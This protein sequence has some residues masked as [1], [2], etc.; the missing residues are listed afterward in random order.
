M[1]KSGIHTANTCKLCGSKNIVDVY[2]QD[3]SYT[4]IKNKKIKMTIAACSK[5]GYV[6]QKSAYSPVYDKYMASTYLQYTRDAKY[7]FP[8]R[9]KDNADAIK[10]ICKGTKHLKAMNVLEIGSNR[11]DLL[12]LLKEKK[13]SINIIGIEPSKI[14]DAAVPTIHSE[15]NSKLF[16]NK[17]DLIIMQHVLEHLKYPSLVIEDIREL[18]APGGY[19]YIEVPNLDNCL[20][21]YLEDFV[22]EHVSYFSEASL[23]SVMRGFDIK[24]HKSQ[25]HIRI[26]AKKSDRKSKPGMKTDILAIKNRFQDFAHNKQRLM[27]QIEKHSNAGHKIVF[28]GISYYFRFLFK[29][30]TANMNKAELYYYDDSMKTKREESFGLRRIDKIDK[31]CLVVICSTVLEVQNAIKNRLKGAH[32]AIVVAPWRE[33]IKI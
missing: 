28:Y 13:P 31:N 6:F 18:L 24:S 26:L 20:K 30:I 19:L 22:P 2:D 8:N 23:R 32:G 10:F 29:Q 3:L 5:C 27:K 16:S 14:D 21:H 1:K 12:Y 9:K 11:G 15:F 33:I 25:S 4:F 7:V 17:F